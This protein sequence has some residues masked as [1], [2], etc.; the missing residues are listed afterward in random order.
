MTM[1][2][3]TQV[4]GSGSET[5]FQAKYD[6][7]GR[8]KN[9]ELQG[10]EF[11]Y[12]PDGSVEI[13]RNQ[14]IIGT[15]Q[16]TST[17]QVTAV[18]N[19]EGIAWSVEK[20]DSD[21]DT[22][23]IKTSDPT[24]S[25]T[26]KTNPQGQIEDVSHSEMGSLFKISRTTPG[27]PLSITDQFDATT[28]LE[29]DEQ[30]RLQ[31]IT[32]GYEEHTIDFTYNEKGRLIALKD[33]D[34]LILKLNH[35]GEP[36]TDSVQI[37]DTANIKI[38]RDE[39]GRPFEIV[40]PSGEK[41]H[42]T[43]DEQNRLVKLETPF[44]SYEL[45]EDSGDKLTL[46]DGEGRQLSYTFDQFGRLQNVRDAQGATIQL[47]WNSIG[48]LVNFIGP[49]ANTIG[50]NWDKRDRITE[51]KD[52]R[53]DKHIKIK[54]DIM[55]RVTSIE[56]GQEQLQLEYDALGRLQKLKQENASDT[57]IVH[58]DKRR[59]IRVENEDGSVNFERDLA[60][61]VVRSEDIN[62]HEV[63]YRFSPGDRLE[64]IGYPASGNWLDNLRDL[65]LGSNHT[66][67]SYEYDES[68][69]VKKIYTGDENSTTVEFIRDVD[70]RITQ[71]KSGE[72]TIQRQ[73][74][75]GFLPSQIQ[76]TTADGNVL[77]EVSYQYDQ[78]GRCIKESGSNGERTYTY[79]AAGRLQKTRYEDYTEIYNYDNSGN[80]LNLQIEG[81]EVT[82]KIL[83]KPL[84]SSINWNE[85]I[86]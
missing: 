53:Q 9:L 22:A 29:Y 3:L 14:E 74:F 34:G 47:E 68:G 5:K 32:N 49:D 66:Q 65:L 63:R 21:I 7:K 19:Q 36:G 37:E 8:V 40:N 17:G 38:E 83:K 64:R 44:S 76:V 58:D 84:Y 28:N 16:Y 45:T 18:E 30:N 31:R 35:T 85:K 43:W 20:N 46:L 59:R 54:R 15:V 39:L 55:N 42:L 13:Q 23:Q 73:Y 6:G 62:G 12:Q 10:L 67:M 82:R 52:N 70:G 48:H 24:K 51:I 41:I 72:I 11:V 26:I 79:D 75:G 27:Q 2:M 4:Q 25:L 56:A 57:E 33:P 81:S 69:Q 61:R 77:Y 78:S 71:V 80:R 60:N 86:F 50:L 1:G